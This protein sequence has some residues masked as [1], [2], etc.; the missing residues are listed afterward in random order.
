MR[1]LY[2]IVSTSAIPK[3]VLYFASL[4]YVVAKPHT[5]CIIVRGL[6]NVMKQ[7]WYSHGSPMEV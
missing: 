3:E 2:S 1:V 7:V 6:F 5:S 4:S